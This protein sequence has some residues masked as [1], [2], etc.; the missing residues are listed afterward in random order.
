MGEKAYTIIWARKKLGKLAVQLTDEQILVLIDQVKAFADV[1]V[2][3]ID[4]KIRVEGTDSM[5]TW[6]N[7]VKL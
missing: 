2:D 4:K 7:E 3:K 1:C 5:Y 6:H